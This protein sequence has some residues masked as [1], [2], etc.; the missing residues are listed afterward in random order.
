MS[1]SQKRGETGDDGFISYA[2]DR[3][4]I[5]NGSLDGEAVGHFERV[6]QLLRGGYDLL[7]WVAGIASVH[8]HVFHS[9]TGRL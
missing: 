5:M 4:Q 1:P 8:N 6:V 7:L 3:W 9:A 2:V